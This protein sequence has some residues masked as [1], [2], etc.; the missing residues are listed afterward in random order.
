MSLSKIDKEHMNGLLMSL[1]N[2]DINI[3]ESIK[4][5]HCH[6]ARL[7]QIDKQIQ[8][9]K[10][11]A[12]SIIQDSQSQSELHKISKNFRLVSG[13]YYYLY[14]KND[15]KYFSMI[16]PDEWN[17]FDIF[18]GKYYYDYDKQFVLDENI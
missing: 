7:K 18:L 8:Q 11:E 4:S 16:S 6:Y 10:Q 17:T 1:N 13:T 9:L 15:K 14:L 2:N 3:I 12:Y 5:N